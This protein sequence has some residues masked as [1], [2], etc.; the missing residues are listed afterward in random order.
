MKKLVVLISCLLITM[1]LVRPATAGVFGTAGILKSGHFAL[2]LEPEIT[3]S[4]S[5]LTLWIHGGL[6]LTRSIDLDVKIGIGSGTIIGA[7]LEF[8]LIRDTKKTI[9]VSFAAGA[10]GSSNL[11]LDATIL[12]S[13]NFRTFS[14]FGALD[15]DIEFVDTGNETEIIIPLYLDLGVGIPIARQMEFIFEGNIGVTNS[16]T[17]SLSGGLMFYF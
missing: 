10:H 12:L 3:F 4:P 9:G 1:S 13:N 7:D 11:G 2:G 14:F 17:S 16:A 5:Q 6:G 15:A 8:G